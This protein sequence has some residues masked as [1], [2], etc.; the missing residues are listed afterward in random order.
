MNKIPL[1][2]VP[3]LCVTY[4]NVHLYKNNISNFHINVL[5]F[6]YFFSHSNLTAEVSY[7]VLFVCT[8]YP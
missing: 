7:N 3:D 2:S 4:Q 5:H 8:L 6:N 1:K